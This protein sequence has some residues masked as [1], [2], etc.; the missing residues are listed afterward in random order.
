MMLSPLS[1]GPHTLH[2]TGSSTYMGMPF[3]QDVTYSLMIE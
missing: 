3:T 1:A 2:F